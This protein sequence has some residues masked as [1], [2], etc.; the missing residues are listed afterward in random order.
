MKPLLLLFVPFSAA[1]EI[2]TWKEGRTTRI[3]TEAPAWYRAETPV[4]GP[5]VIVI[6][7]KRVADDTALSMEERWRLKPQEHA[8][9]PAGR[10]P[11]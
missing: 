6:T 8:P 7:G 10:R 1:A 11:R 5:R 3:S 9:I 4:K 2:Y